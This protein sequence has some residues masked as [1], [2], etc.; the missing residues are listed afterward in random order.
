MAGLTGQAGPGHAP[1]VEEFGSP[2]P[3]ASGHRLGGGRVQAHEPL[4]TAPHAGQ[5]V[6]AE[7]P[8]RPGCPS[9]I[10]VLTNLLTNAF[11]VDVEFPV[12]VPDQPALVSR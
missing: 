7:L 10:N 6:H 4:H 12:V 1:F 11:A 2:A 5:Q 3:G 9:R 8:V